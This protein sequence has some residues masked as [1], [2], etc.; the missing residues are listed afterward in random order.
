MNIRLSGYE[1][2][3]IVDGPGVRFTIFVQGCPHHCKGCHNP[4]THDFHGG[5]ETTTNEIFELI[6]KE[7]LLISGVTFSGGEPFCQKE[8]LIELSEKCH[9][10]GLDVVC[11]TGY[12]YEEILKD[13]DSRIL[14]ASVDYLVDGKFEIDKKSYN[15]PFRG[16]LNQRF[17]DVKKSL[18]CGF[19]VEKIF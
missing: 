4:Q 9:K 12:T 5:Y 11:F 7:E 13:T 8:S 15:I 3:S 10:L 19:V 17:I 18:N 6:K 1:P 14:L 16:S 2:N